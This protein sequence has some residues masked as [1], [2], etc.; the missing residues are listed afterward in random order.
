M[1]T[2]TLLALKSEKAVGEVFNVSPGN[3]VTN[4]ELAS[5]LSKVTGFKGKLVFGSYPPGYPSRPV[6]QDPD[7]LVL[8]S[9]KIRKLLGW[10]PSVSLEEGLTKTVES[11]KT[12]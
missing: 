12:T 9:S 5:A 1:S 8:D 7:Y 10:K 11:W 4:E 6:A 3:P 2:L